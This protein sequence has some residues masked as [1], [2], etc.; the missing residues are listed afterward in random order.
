MDEKITI[1]IQCGAEQLKVEISPTASVLQFKEAFA[2]KQSILG[3]DEMRMIFKGKI[4]KDEMTLEYYKITDGL[5][6]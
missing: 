6:V 2:T 4:L 5:T 3:A 1:I